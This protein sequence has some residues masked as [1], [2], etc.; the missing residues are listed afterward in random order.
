MQRVKFIAALM[1]LFGLILLSVVASI[2]LGQDTLAQYETLYSV[3]WSPDGTRLLAGEY[4][5]MVLVWDAITGQE[6]FRFTD[7]DNKIG[8]GGRGRWSPDGTQIATWSMD[9]S[10]RLWDAANGELLHTLEGHTGEIVSAFFS[11]DGT[12]LLTI[13]EDS[14]ARIWDAATGEMQLTYTA[15]EKML[16][17]AEWT[18]DGAHIATSSDDGTAHIWD[19]NTGETL[20]VLAERE[21]TEMQLVGSIG[22]EAYGVAWSPD[23]TRLAVTGTD[24]AAIVFDAATGEKKQVLHVPTAGGLLPDFV[25]DSYWSPDG[26][27]LLLHT[28]E[29]PPSIW[30]VDSGEVQYVITGHEDIV[31]RTRWSADGAIVMTTGVDG[32]MRFID[33]ATGEWELVDTKESLWSAEFSPDGSLIATTSSEGTVRL[34][35]AVTHEEYQFIFP[36]A[37]GNAV[38]QAPWRDAQLTFAAEMS[39]TVGALCQMMSNFETAEAGNNEVILCANVP[40]TLSYSGAKDETLTF[41]LTAQSGVRLRVLAPD[42][43]VVAET[44]T[45]TL[46]VMLPADGIYEF[47]ISLLIPT[48][49]IFDYVEVTVRMDT[50]LSAAT[51]TP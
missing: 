29:N 46:T 4:T 6:L 20:F 1:S 26:T 27:R 13:S 40:V 23:E 16:E 38:I 37:S 24:G 35:D 15:H 12:H 44:E 42:R 11:P 22:V 47:E 21:P 25:I 17:D 18:D 14:T 2:V 28:L 19:A 50:S 49:Q 45:N 39:P 41:E 32:T 31:T 34:W 3:Q 7:H 51:P 36:P 9:N 43:T 30:N 33:S 10:A 5:G 8:N 48:T